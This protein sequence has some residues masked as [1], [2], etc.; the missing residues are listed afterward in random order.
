V[1]HLISIAGV[2]LLFALVGLQFLSGLSF[3]FIAGFVIVSQRLFKKSTG[4]E[5]NQYDE[6]ALIKHLL[7]K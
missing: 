2:G 1:W 3:G 6:D 4:R 5:M 7:S